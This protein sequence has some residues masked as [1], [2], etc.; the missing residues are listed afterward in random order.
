MP[1]ARFEQRL[2]V[3]RHDANPLVINQ[4]TGTVNL[5]TSRKLSGACVRVLGIRQA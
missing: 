4:R 1:S 2:V 5:L 3:Q